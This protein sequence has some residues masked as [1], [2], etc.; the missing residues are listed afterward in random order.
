MSSL[1]Q[2][3]L[4]ILIFLKAT[5]SL[6]QSKCS[7]KY[8]TFTKDDLFID[9]G[10]YASINKCGTPYAKHYFL[11]KFINAYW[12]DIQSIC[13]SYDMDFV[14]F[15]RGREAQ[16]LLENLIK[17]LTHEY[18]EKKIFADIFI[19]GVT[20]VSGSK[21]FT[22]SHTGKNMN[23]TLQ[24]STLR[25]IHEPNGKEYGNYGEEQCLA[26]SKVDAYHKT[27]GYSDVICSGRTSGRVLCEKYVDQVDKRRF[28]SRRPGRNFPKVPKGFQKAL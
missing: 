21:N 18:E 9:L 16:A 15:E 23:F 26:I 19:G 20:H 25:Y 10:V 17:K 6:D 4:I 22:N 7:L 2:V 3:L 1:N 11:S 12:Y 28:L 13:E 8:K 27:L 5:I 24:W 14:S